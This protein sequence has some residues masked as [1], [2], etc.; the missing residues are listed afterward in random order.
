VPAF[1]QSLEIVGT[2]IAPEFGAVAVAVLAGVVAMTIV[3]T[4]RS[5]LFGARA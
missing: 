2:S 4:R 5:G 1:S 3:L